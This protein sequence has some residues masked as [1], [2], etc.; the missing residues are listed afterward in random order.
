MCAALS[1]PSIQDRPAVE[2]LIRDFAGSAPLEVE[3]SPPNHLRLNSPDG[4]IV[5]IR[6]AHQGLPTV[7]SAFG[8]GEEFIRQVDQLK[9][10]L[11]GKFPT[12]DCP[13]AG[14]IA[15]RIYNK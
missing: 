11:E 5:I 1:I 9:A 2:A 15:P 10:Q 12:V 4:G 7:F 13:E 8:G 3:G 14:I 6:F